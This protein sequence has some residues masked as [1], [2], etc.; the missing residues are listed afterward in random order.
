M[1]PKTLNTTGSYYMFCG[2]DLRP[3]QGG[4]CW[5]DAA[6]RCV[7]GQLGAIMELDCEEFSTRARQKYHCGEAKCIAHPI[8][9][10][11]FPSLPDEQ[12][13]ALLPSLLQPRDRGHIETL[14][15]PV[16]RLRLPGEAFPKLVP[17]PPRL[18]APSPPSVHDL[19][20][21]PHQPLQHGL[22]TI[23]HGDDDEKAITQ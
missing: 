15:A 13:D 23:R 7:N 16:G 5:N 22:H 20:S 8:A 1:C 10:K 12:M 21:Q 17:P 11:N 6:Y 3:K 14:D 9:I 18:L 4:T 2:P 19:Q